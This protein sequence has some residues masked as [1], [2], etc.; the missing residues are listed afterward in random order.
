MFNSWDARKQKIFNEIYENI[1]WEI[2]ESKTDSSIT[3]SLKFFPEPTSDIKE[4]FPEM[5]IVYKDRA[6]FDER[7]NEHYDS[8]ARYMTFVAV[9]EPL[10][11]KYDEEWVGFVKVETTDMLPT[12]PETSTPF[13]RFWRFKTSKGK[14][15]FVWGPIDGFY[16]RM[17]QTREG[18]RNSKLSLLK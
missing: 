9:K 3:V 2:K 8:A 5:T 1:T 14:L 11:L 17:V 13:K 18:F 6:E 15:S 12:S 10:I 16:E 4:E 7:S